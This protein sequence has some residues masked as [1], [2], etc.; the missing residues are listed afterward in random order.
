MDAELKEYLSRE[1]K[2]FSIQ[3]NSLYKSAKS[4]NN[5]V[6]ASYQFANNTAKHGKPFSDSYYIKETV[7]L[8]SHYLKTSVL[9]QG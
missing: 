8:C 3:C 1:L 6:A 2:S 4:E 9:N 5:I 7:G